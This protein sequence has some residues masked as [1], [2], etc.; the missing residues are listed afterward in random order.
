MQSIGLLLPIQVGDDDSN[1]VRYNSTSTYVVVKVYVTGQTRDHE[2]EL[3]IYK[4][5]NFEES[6]HPGRNFIRK[7][8]D[9]FYIQGPHGRHVCLVHEP[10]GTSADFLVKLSLD[11]Q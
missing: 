7:L 8:L 9:H 2:R 11:R 6:R 3:D 1:G 4:H 10:L 5:M